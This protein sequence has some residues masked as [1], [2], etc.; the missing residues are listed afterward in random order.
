M[1][2]TTS[3]GSGCSGTGRGVS[4]AV[5]LRA[6]VWNNNPLQTPPAD[7]ST[8]PGRP[9]GGSGLSNLSEKRPRATL[10]EVRSE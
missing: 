2:P 5:E 7:S 10:D 6:G 4:A 8:P 3:S 9:A 1:E